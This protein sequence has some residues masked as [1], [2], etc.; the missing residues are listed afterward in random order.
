MLLSKGAALPYKAEREGALIEEYVLV[1]GDDAP[2]LSQ[3]NLPADSEVERDATIPP[4]PTLLMNT[5][6]HWAACKGHL[7]I[8]WLLI[9]QGYSPN[10]VDDVQNTPLHLAAANGH[11]HVV[12]CLVED[13]ADPRAKN[14][15]RNTPLD[16]STVRPVRECL[17]KAADAPASSAAAEAALAS[18]HAENLESYYRVESELRELVEGRA[19][20]ETAD[21]IVRLRAALQAAEEVDISK[22]AIEAGRRAVEML[23]LKKELTEQ[24]ILVNANQPIVTQ[25][26]YVSLVNKLARLVKQGDALAVPA[27]LIEEAEFLI[28]KSHAEYWLRMGCNKLAPLECAGDDDVGDMDRLKKSIA[29]AEGMRA[30][31]SLVKAAKVL[32]D[33]LDGELELRRAID[34]I[35]QVKLPIAEPPKDYWAEDDLGRIEDDYPDFPLPPESG[36]YVWIPAKSLALLRTAAERLDSA[37]E[38]AKRS[39]ANAAL[40]GEAGEKAKVSADELKQLERK[41]DEDRELIFMQTEKAAKK[42]KK[43][44]KK[45]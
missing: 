2:K 42:L 41:D 10:D 13:G 25:T 31:E 28:K 26:A 29:K 30:E 1:D 17:L 38:A 44:K 40:I 9:E 7:R 15:F 36:E 6:L 18:K 16:V 22:G 34:A 37:L 45:K 8:A 12:N 27:Q 4:L 39:E 20:L 5:P 3:T 19:S 23:E 32:R 11:V 43:K 14:A 24:I 21:A 33:R 35:P